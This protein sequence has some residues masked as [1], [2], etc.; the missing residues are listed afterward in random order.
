MIRINIIGTG[1]LDIEEGVAL[2]FK[3]DNQQFRF[4]EIGL[5][6]SVEFSVPDTQRNRGLLGFSDD[7]AQS[8]EIMR[9]SV[10]CQVIH[11]GGAFNGTL[12][13]TGFEGNAFRCAVI[14]GNA[15][16]INEL[17]SLKVSDMAT[18]WDKG[19][20]WSSNSWISADD[21]SLFVFVG[22]I[23]LKILPYENGLS[24]MPNWSYLPSI[25][26]KALIKDLL[27]VRG[28]P[29]DIQLPHDYWLVANT[30]KG[31][32][33]ETITMAS[34]GTTNLTISQGH[35]FFD[36]VDIDIEW[37]TGVAF[38]QL[39]GGGSTLAKG[40]K[41]KENIQLTFPSSFPTDC[42]LVQYSSK[43]KKCY[44]LGGVT[45]NGMMD[46]H[47]DGTGALDGRT[48][49][50][51]KGYT[52]FFAPN[53]WLNTF[54]QPDGWLGYQDT[55]NPFSFVFN[56][57]VDDDIAYGDPWYI[58]YNMPDCT[59]FELL[60]SA[61]LAA[62]MELFVDDSGVAIK[63]GAYG[64]GVKALENVISV[65]AVTRRVDG[66]GNNTRNVEIAFDSEE[67]VQQP[68]G[69]NYP[70]DNDQ[71][72]DDKTIKTKFSE[73]NVGTNGVEILDVEY[74]AG[75][76]TYKLKAK[77]PT[78]VF[79]DG[80][81]PTL[82]R[83]P[84]VEMVACGDIGSESTSLRVKV[85]TDEGEFFALKETDVLLWRGMAYVWSAADW[86]NGVM[87]LTLQKVSQPTPAIP[88][89]PA[90]PTPAD[91]VQDGLVLL[92]DGIEQGG[93]ADVWTSLVGGHVFTPS[94]GVTF[95]DNCVVFDGIDG[96]MLNSSF[97]TPST[98]SGTIEVVYSSNGG[99]GVIYMPKSGAK[100]LAFSIDSNYYSIYTN[101]SSSPRYVMAAKASASVS[102]D[103]GWCNGVAA[104]QDGSSSLLS[105]HT[106]NNRIGC[107]YNSSTNQTFFNGKIFCI[108]IY[109]RR[110]TAAEVEAN[111]QVDIARFGI[112]N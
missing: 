19:I 68:I 65:D 102:D 111:R 78:I 75:N 49:E 103:G 88:L 83:I 28:I 30:L 40:F 27:D 20:I 37:A 84:D 46:D 29:N 25:N 61:A 26:L 82:Q 24:S 89:P 45:S 107:R 41:A 90:P 21:P 2:G 48:V 33:M 59:F 52:Y 76:N 39:I 6:R 73:G 4:C 16:W 57:V 110:L 74:D 35:Q 58:A 31:S 71:T 54:Y 50:L 100:R 104:T 15:T 9:R 92:M 69:W 12:N 51:K 42:F 5:G 96:R 62:G 43:L 7:P 91:Y 106:T 36:V 17:Q 32:G 55:Y 60:K 95:D 64:V 98:S 97:S 77:K 94:G 67:Y 109:N 44:T 13:V 47:G 23:G 56:V 10:P 99:F 38:N 1:F 8:G 79:A 18:S 72:T 11:D 81:M 85:R 3:K 101:V 63:Q 53:R 105:S 14:I 87:S 66:W 34:T 22:G 70:V 108:R 80:T 112:G 86:A 93:T